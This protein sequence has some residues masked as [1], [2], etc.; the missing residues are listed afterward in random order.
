M[1]GPMSDDE[2]RSGYRRIGAGFVGIVGLSAGMMALSGG[3]SMAQAG[4][5]TVGGVLVGLMLLFYLIRSR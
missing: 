4:A 5:V 3:A 2:R 1:V